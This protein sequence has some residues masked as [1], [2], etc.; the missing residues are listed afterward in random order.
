MK[1]ILTTA[2]TLMLLAGSAA[3]A[4][5]DRQRHDRRDHHSDNYRGER[6]DWRDHDR[7]APRRDWNGR[8]DRRDWDRRDHP[9]QRNRHDRDHDARRWNHDRD[10]RDWN[11]RRWNDSRSWQP[12]RDPWPYRFSAGRYDR[13]FG[14]REYAWHRG[15]RLPAA[16]YAPR[17]VVRDYGAYHLRRPPGGYHWIRV[18]SDVVLAAVAS[19]LV[20]EVVSGLFY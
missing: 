14:Y 15:A 7:G 3:V 1:A 19:G 10:A 5:S 16:Y 18:D 6:H 13:P 20:V 2:M 17:Y 12:R 4:D 9:E 11:D 8:Q